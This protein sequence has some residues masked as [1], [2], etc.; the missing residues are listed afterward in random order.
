MMAPMIARMLCRYAHSWT[1]SQQYHEPL[2]FRQPPMKTIR[3]LLVAAGVCLL[4]A[5]SFGQQPAPV[6]AQLV[7]VPTT[8]SEAA[9]APTSESAADPS[10]TRSLDQQI[11][12][13]KKDV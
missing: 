6:P 4:S 9:A 8:R 1:T 10:G 7:P 5:A 12:D 2:F 11:Q 3:Q 13:L